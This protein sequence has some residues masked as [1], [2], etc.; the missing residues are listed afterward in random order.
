MFRKAMVPVALLLTAIAVAA[1]GGSGTPHH[2]STSSATSR[3]SAGLKLAECMRAHGVPNYPD[4]SAT[5][6]GGTQIRQSS[7]ASG[8]SIAVDG[9]QLDAS[10][11]KFAEAMHSCLKYQPRGPA[12]SGAQLARIKQGALKMAQCMRTHGVPN[13]SDPQVTVGPGGHGIGVRLGAGSVAGA[14]VK[15]TTPPPAFQR[16]MN[17]CQAYMQFG[18]KGQKA[19]G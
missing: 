7:G 5:G 12:I 2:P 9:V 17:A 15:G 13:F 16:A 3:Q 1:C 8:N 19:V 6:G 18:P 10:A 14:G 11:P 4:P